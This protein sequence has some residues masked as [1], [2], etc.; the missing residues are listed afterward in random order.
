[1][2]EKELL[3]MINHRK[4]E[5]NKIKM[6][7]N[8]KLPVV[9]WGA[10][11]LAASVRKFLIK[12]DIKIYAC[13]VENGYEANK[14]FYNIP[15]MNL[16]KLEQSFKNINLV[17]GHA[18]YDLRFNM[19]KK[20]RIVNKVF[21]FCNICYERYTSISYDFIK[22]NIGKYYEAYNQLHD[23]ESKKCMIAYLN[24]RLNDDICY[25]EACMNK[26]NNGYFKNEL[27]EVSEDETYLDLGAYTG[28]TVQ[29]FLNVCN[30]KYQRIIAFEPENE[31]FNTLEKYIKDN[32][33]LLYKFGCYDR[34]TKLYFSEKEESSGITVKEG[35]SSIEVIDLDS[36][37][38]DENISIIKL[39][40]L[41]GV[42]ETLYGARKLLIRNMPKLAITV[43]F[44]DITMANAILFLKEINKECIDNNREKYTIMLRYNSA[45]PSRLILYACRK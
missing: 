38:L 41:Y 27:F 40:Y 39:N 12:N 37:I 24:S 6:L 3:E 9:L 43:G 13:L 31:S 17:L 8:D 14:F 33:T 11:S 30:G 25:I 1:M 45:M 19:K 21:Y 7:K 35:D 32:N 28:D 20:S 18:R 44:D 42:M 2:D 26:N 5:E 15:I 10:G 34:K 36:L 29:Q 22:K 4:S 23:D 16:E